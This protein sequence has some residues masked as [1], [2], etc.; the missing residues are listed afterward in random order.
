MRR[1]LSITE[2]VAAFF[3]LAI[4]LLIT[5]NVVL[6]KSLSVQIPDNFDISKLMQGIALFWGI[7]IAT[8]YGGHI[9]VDIVWEAM[10][11][12]GR[13]LLDTT[14]TLVTFLFLAP[15]AW[16][17]WVKVANTG[18]QATSD[19]RLPMAPF[20]AVAALGAT[21]AAALALWRLVRLALHRPPEAD[22][23]GAAAGGATHG[24]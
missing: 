2:N 24:S 14:A 5:V 7:A 3:L 10:G 18:T 17:T 16:M 4:A 13:R 11:R 15:L 6:R 1:F 19:L 23:A 12:A 22:L 21:A 8:Y 9:C 20:F